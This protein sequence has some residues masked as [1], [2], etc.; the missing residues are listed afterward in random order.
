MIENWADLQSYLKADKNALGIKRK[1]CIPF[2]DRIWLFEIQLRYTEYFY[3]NRQK[4]LLYAIIGSLM[5]AI[6]KYK[7]RKMSLEIPL[8]VIDKGLRIWHGHGIIINSKAKIGKNF[9]ISAGC[10]VGQAKDAY[11]IIGNNVEMT[12]HSMVLG[13][14]TICDDVIIAPGACVVKNVDVPFCTVGG[15]PAKIINQ[16]VPNE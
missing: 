12:I 2:K 1:F 8:N 3:N 14:I 6:W 11:P 13:G 4:N 7:T 15:V 16:R 9:S 5:S 10:V